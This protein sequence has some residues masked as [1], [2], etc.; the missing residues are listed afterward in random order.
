MDKG[1]FTQNTKN[2]ALAMSINPIARIFRLTWVRTV[3]IA[4]LILPVIHYCLAILCRQLYF[5][6]GT[7]AIW[8]STGV[9]LA[10]VLLFRYRI[11]PAIVVSELIVNASLFYQDNI[12]FGSSQA[13]IGVID[14]LVAGYLINRF[15]LRRYILEQTGDVFKFA[16]LLVPS[17]VVTTTLCITSLCLV[18]KTAWADYQ[19][20]WW[21]W[22]TATYAGE[23][24][25][26]PAIL[27]WFWPSLRYRS[28]SWQQFVELA[29]LLSAA[30]AICRVA[31][32]DGYPLEYT[33]VALLIW[34]A[35]RLGGRGA[36]LM[37]VVVSAIA[38]YGTSHGFGSF[39]RQSVKESLLLLQSF[40]SVVALTT[41]ILSAAIAE[42]KI[43]QTNL[44]NAKNELELRVEER[45]KELKQAK[46]T[47]E[48]ANQA[49]SEFLANMSH[50]LRTPLNG[51]LGYAQILQKS[52]TF[53]E[54]ERN[55][56]NII[57]Q[58]GSHLLTLIN[59]ILDLSKIEARKMELDLNDFHFPSFLEG[60]SEICRIKADQKEI[61][62]NYQPS[63]QLPETIHAD[64]KRLRQVLI[65]LL[66]NA[67][68]FTIQGQVTFKV[69]V[70]G[71]RHDQ[72]PITQLRF[73][74]ED[75][76]IG[77]NKQQI[78]TI[79]LPFEQVGTLDKRGEGT[80]LGLA[81]SQK[82]VSLMGS[83]IQVESQ[84]NKGSIFRFDVELPAALNIKKYDKFE[85]LNHII[86]IEGVKRKILIVDELWENRSVA[87]NLLLPLGFEIFEANN[88]QSG[89]EKA[90]EIQPDLIITDLRMPI[91]D[92]LTM[93]QHLRQLPNLQNVTIIAS[94]ASVFDFQRQ[95]ALDMGCDD[96]LA[97]PIQLEQLLEQLQNHLDL[98]WIYQTEN[99]S[100]TKSDLT[101]EMVFPPASEIA[102]LYQAAVRCDVVVV[103]SEANRIKKL[104]PKYIAFSEQLLTLADEFDVEAIAEL[105]HPYLSDN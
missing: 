23:L 21:G 87:V 91:M 92:G 102:K 17:L 9:Y 83:T 94:S 24:I 51:I 20:A 42:N 86:G 30:S 93:T 54:K 82:I 71:Y 4:L 97:K 47:A 72:L 77:I 99:E 89:L 44:K 69:D 63:A 49:K 1:N 36:T 78:N 31:F 8:P 25:V 26:A 76:G 64:E 57:H 18:G 28:Y 58:C 39:Y 7:T 10:T 45:T 61:A 35:F 96:F 46:L 43:A 74:I 53:T 80:G 32:W 60:V 67:I 33:I 75:T 52:K 38:V 104:D 29:L 81:I 95:A 88:G 100:F 37:V 66:G 2:E 5:E 98:T 27:A 34:A 19:G 84:E 16:V 6:D 55:G 3:L 101:V 41:Y 13:V 48:K 14:P 65:N 105:V 12:L 11:W 62:F 90:R 40:I 79:F 22:F 73:Q 70:F 85:Q 56:I 15:T 59:D 50:E 103:E 68:K